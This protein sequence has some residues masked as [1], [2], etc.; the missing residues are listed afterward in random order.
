MDNNSH[1]NYMPISPSVL[2]LLS[3]FK[4]PILSLC[5]DI[6]NEIEYFWDNGLPDYIDSL[7][8]KFANTKTF[9]YRDETISFYDVFFPVSLKLGHAGK[10]TVSYDDLFFNS[11]YVTIIGTAGCGKTML[12]KHFFLATINETFRIPILIELRNLNHY[13]KSFTEYIYEHIFNNKLS[14]D[15]RILERLLES[16]QFFILLDG[17]DEIFSERKNKITEDIDKFI[18][19][20]SKNLFLISSRPGSGIESLPRFSNYYVQQLSNDEVFLFID[21]VLKDNVDKD[22][23][24]KIKNVINQSF[25]KEYSDFLR[26]PLLLSMFILTFNTYPELPTKKSKFYWNV[27]DT[28]ATKHDS[29][30]KQG[31]YQHERKTKLQNDDFEQILR[32]FSFKSLLDGELNFDASYLNTKL[33][34]IKKALKYD[35]NIN[36]L[37]DDL[38]LAIP[39]IV[40]DGIEYKFPHKSIQEY[41]C[42][43]LVKQQT[44]EN[45]E[46]IYK[47]KF[48]L[49]IRSSIGGYENLW[50]L[51][52]EVDR[53]SFLKF[54]ILPILENFKRKVFD[55]DPVNQLRKYYSFSG[56]ADSIEFDNDDNIKFAGG[57][58]YLLS[59]SPYIAIF[60]YL[61]IGNL[62]DLLPSRLHYKQRD[63]DLLNSI[64]EFILDNIEDFEKIS[65]TNED[66]EITF[67]FNVNNHFEN[68]KDTILKLGKAYEE[69]A[70]IFDSLNQKLKD[71]KDEIH[72]ESQMTNS[73]IDLQ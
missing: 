71:L 15:K 59:F 73:L 70:A 68:L 22:L 55:E 19:R 37:V 10:E 58:V 33:A 57:D 23:A 48:L 51:C 64:N 50:N 11:Q 13:D 14:P 38:T 61:K 21:K 45:K 36:D 31:G 4:D 18:D 29:F 44:D 56:L 35:F 47:E 65:E 24:T 41:F 49:L 26:S 2:T 25:D 66:G 53:I 60:R 28:L 27:F 16:G 20:Y 1:Q 6:K 67:D 30:T 8:K 9:L 34:E 7:E 5:S 3:T 54:F 40:I 52:S 43:M 42:A 17:Y 32:W 62:F 63:N 12:M 46:K 72:I 69:M 39:I